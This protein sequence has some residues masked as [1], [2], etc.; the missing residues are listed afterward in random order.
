MHLSSIHSS[1]LKNESRP[2]R[3]AGRIVTLWQLKLNGIKTLEIP[4]GILSGGA[5]M[6]QSTIASANEL[7][8]NENHELMERKS[9]KS[10]NSCILIT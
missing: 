3:R 2:L 4:C 1:I 8:S 9:E 6:M 5:L 7:C 10:W